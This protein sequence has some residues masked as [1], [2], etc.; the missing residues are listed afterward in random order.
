MTAGYPNPAAN[1]AVA[2]IL[3]V[4][5]T[6]LVGARFAL[7]LA[8]NMDL[9]ADDW[10]CLPA[11]VRSVSQIPFLALSL[12]FLGLRLGMRWCI[13]MGYQATDIWISHA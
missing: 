13:N 1:Y 4:I 2:I 8:R 9:Q 7:R 5:G 12:T 3:P 6:V 10:F 11:L